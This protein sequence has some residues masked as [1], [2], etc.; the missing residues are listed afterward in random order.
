MTKGRVI[1]N[2]NG[3][4]YVDVGRDNLVECRRRGKLLKAKILVGDEL[5]TTRA[6]SKPSCLGGIK[7]AG[8]RW[9]TSIN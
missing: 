6:S 1:K 5:E 4:Y 8:R 7:S 9:R 3:Y 2:Y